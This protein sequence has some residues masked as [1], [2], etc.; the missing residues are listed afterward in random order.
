LEV[1]AMGDLLLEKNKQEKGKKEKKRA[2]GEVL[3]L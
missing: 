2:N 3:L 1:R